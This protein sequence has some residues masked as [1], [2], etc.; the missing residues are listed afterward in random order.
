MIEIY[1][2][3]LTNRE[4]EFLVN[5]Y[6]SNIDKEVV[7]IDDIYSFKSVH[8]TNYKSLTLFNRLS[9][10]NLPFLRVQLLDSEIPIV[11]KMH[12]HTRNWTFVG[13]LNDEFEGGE[14]IIENV[15]ITP[16]KNMF[17]IFRGDLQHKVTKIKSGKRYTLVSFM[18]TKPIINSNLI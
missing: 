14:L 16:K 2:N 10:K 6:D 5:Y 17:V 8:I 7:H 15:K 11:E 3:F 4:S 1:K 18:D 12:A 13:F 9:V